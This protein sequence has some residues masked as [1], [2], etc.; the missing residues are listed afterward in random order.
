VKMQVSLKEGTPSSPS[1]Q[2]ITPLGSVSD[3]QTAKNYMECNTIH[4]TANYLSI[5]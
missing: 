4:G 1:E 3:G 5:H 2:V